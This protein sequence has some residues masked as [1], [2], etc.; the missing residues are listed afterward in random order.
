MNHYR[1]PPSPHHYNRRHV[2]GE[3][4]GT[5]LVPHQ[6][7]RELGCVAAS[8]QTSLLSCFPQRPPAAEAAAELGLQVRR[9]SQSIKG[10]SI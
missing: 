2:S 4:D 5:L 3:W 1:P 8:R 9:Q 6:Q 7:L 10:Q